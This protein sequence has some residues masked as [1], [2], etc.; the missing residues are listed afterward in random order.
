LSVALVEFT[1]LDV[2]ALRGLLRVQLQEELAL[3]E[4]SQLLNHLHTSDA[5]LN[6]MINY[7][8][9]EKNIRVWLAKEG[10]R[11]IGF[12]AGQLK[13][14]IYNNCDVITGELL[15]IYVEV[16]FRNNGVGNLLMTK[17]EQWMLQHGAHAA[18]V[19]WLEGNSAS[20]ALYQKKGYTPVY[21]TG[22]KIFEAEDGGKRGG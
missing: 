1:S 7:W 16:D 17:A 9:Q 3:F 21:V 20:Q 19:S 22:R 13:A 4:R 11:V 8:Q 18:N 15:A 12:S 6:R 5:T 2:S 14:D 10:Q